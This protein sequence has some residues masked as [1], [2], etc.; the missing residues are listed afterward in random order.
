MRTWGVLLCSLLLVACA[1]APVAPPPES[2]FR[3]D[4]FVPPSARVSA[5]DV[6]AL[7]PEMR[8]YLKDKIA[9]Q[10]RAKGPQHG[11]VDALYDKTL[12]KL[13]YDAEV[14][15]T[16]AQTFAARAGN[17]LSLVIMTAAFAKEIGLPVRYQ[18]VLVEDSWTRSGTMYF[19]SSHVNLTLDAASLGDRVL[20]FEN[21]PL[22]VDFL[23]PEDIR[24]HRFR[25]I[26]EDTVVAMYMNNRAAELLAQGQ[27]NDAYWWA[28]EA[29]EQDPRFLQAYNTLG[30]VYR[31]QGSLAQAERVLRH[32]LDIE[33]ANTLVMSNLALTYKEE[34]RVEEAKALT[35]KLEQLQPYPPFYFFDLG[36]EA[37]HKGDYKTAKNLFTREIERDAYY[38][39]FHFWLAAAYVGLGDTRHAREQLELA[40][41]TSTTRKEHALYAAKLDR[42]Q[43]LRHEP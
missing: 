21:A 2:L 42:I 8:A 18:R 32:V 41:E 4:L 24:G 36:V 43:S 7:S 17:C 34:G 15:R 6:F 39:E 31:Q 9:P 10:L 22:T 27:T 14:T 25:V 26:E 23:G 3:D 20:D 35:A 11:L 19:S 12:L 29:M 5:D 40:M 16:A 13:D 38:H 37:M 1:S 33:P 30:V 28:R